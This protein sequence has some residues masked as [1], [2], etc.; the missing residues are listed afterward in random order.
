MRALAC[1]APVAAT[2]AADALDSIG[3]AARAGLP[4]EACGVLLGVGR[5][6]DEAVGLANLAATDDRFLIDP[7]AAAKIERQARRRG[8]RLV[9]YFHSHP[10]GPPAPSEADLAG[11]L[12]PGH[13]PD[14]HLIITCSHEARPLRARSQR[15]RLFQAGPQRWRLLENKRQHWRLFRVDPQGWRPLHARV[16]GRPEGRP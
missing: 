2:I 4:R 3:R 11:H 1:H 15:W 5:R 7:L 16:V 8:L 12:W 13:G 6:I 10:H 14:L 9:G